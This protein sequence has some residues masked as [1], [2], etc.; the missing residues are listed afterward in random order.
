MILWR[1][2]VI[3]AAALTMLVSVA[4]AQ[5]G[6]SAFVGGRESLDDA[7]WTGPML[8]P[9]AATLPHGHIL[10]EPYLFD[11]TTRGQ[12]ASNGSRHSAPHSNGFG[13]LTYMLDGLTDKLTLGMIPT[14]G[15]NQVSGGPE[16]LRH[17]LWGSHVA[18]PVPP[19]AIS[20]RELDS[21]NLRRD[22]AN[23]PDR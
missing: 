6:T 14:A 13:S 23:A 11:V 3:M 7:W 1:L 20:R 17:W 8:A 16:Q 9:S 19:S 18:N 5:Q 12:Y 15:Y 21:N 10:I 4:A 22:P 2:I